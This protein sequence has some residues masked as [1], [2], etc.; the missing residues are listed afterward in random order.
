MGGDTNVG[1]ESQVNLMKMQVSP[2]PILQWELKSVPK[3][4]QLRVGVDS[5]S[6]LDQSRTFVQSVDSSQAFVD[7]PPSSDEC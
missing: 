2:E 4:S 6:L 1:A 7:S 3:G 5:Q